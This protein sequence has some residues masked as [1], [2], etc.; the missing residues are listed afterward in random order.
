MAPQW[1]DGH[2]AMKR[3]LYALRLAQHDLPGVT[4]ALALRYG[5]DAYRAFVRKLRLM[6]WGRP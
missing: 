4:Q 1:I 3:A 6:T 5:G 2:A